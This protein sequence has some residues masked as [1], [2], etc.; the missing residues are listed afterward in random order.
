[1]LETYTAVLPSHWASALING[2]RTGLTDE[3]EAEL[4]RVLEL[5]PEWYLPVTC[6]EVGFRWHHDASP[7]GVL[8]GDCCEYTYLREVPIAIE[9][10]SREV[11]ELVMVTR[12]EE[13]QE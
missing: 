3:E 7:Y 10:A 13:E 9:P 6:E 4:D 2:D 5:H 11:V 1:M 8:A 12:L